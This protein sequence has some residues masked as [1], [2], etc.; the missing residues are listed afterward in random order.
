VS[1]SSTLFLRIN[2]RWTKREI[3]KA[4]V[5]NVVTSAFA[6]RVQA[7]AEDAAGNRSAPVTKTRAQG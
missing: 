5:V 4:G 2:G 1:E 6:A 7:I 3:A